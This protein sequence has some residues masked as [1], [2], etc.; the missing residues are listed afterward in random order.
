MLPAQCH[1][2]KLTFLGRAILI[3]SCEILA[4]VA[5]WILAA[6]L[7]RHTEIL[8]YCLIAWTLGLRLACYRDIVSTDPVA[9][10]RH[11][12][13]ADHL[14]AIDLSLRRLLAIN[15]SSL[16]VTVGFWFSLGHSTVVLVATIWCAGICP[17]VSEVH[18]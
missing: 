4:N 13:D 12:L 2:F 17:R 7:F 8:S 3:M 10:A 1:D 11:A 18:V 14:C 5:F 9:S 6:C 15:P 16:P